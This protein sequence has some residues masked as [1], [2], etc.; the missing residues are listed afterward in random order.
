MITYKHASFITEAINSSLEQQLNGT[1]ELIISDDCSPDKTTEIVE[2]IINSYEGDV[3]IRY[4]RNEKNLGVIGNFHFALH[5]SK[6]QFVALCEGDDYW[7]DAQKLQKQLDLLGKS[8]AM[9]CHTGAKDSSGQIRS[10]NI[11][12]QTD[13]SA[14]LIDG[15]FIMT[16]SVV[17]RREVLDDNNWILGNYPFGDWPLWLTALT[18]G[19]IV[20]L[21]EL[22]TVYRINETGV[23]QNNW[24]DRVG[25]D[26]V[27]K[28]IE[29]L[30]EYRKAFSKYEKP[31]L[32]GIISRVKKLA[33]F[34]MESGS[35][36]LVLQ[37]PVRKYAAYD[38]ELKALQKKACSKYIKAKLRL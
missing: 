5:K 30:E 18:K 15:N 8:G 14:P 34:Y 38:P 35:Y 2:G 29:M 3:I 24:K 32:D 33:D 17:F 20:F 26:R 31:V 23:W 13:N 28:E 22:T 27:L 16:A 7:V 11:E 12:L 1:I 6:G 37:N 19:N 10:K 36:R 21:D 25:S 9:L 4:I